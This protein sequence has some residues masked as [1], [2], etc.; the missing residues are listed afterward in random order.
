MTA[1]NDITGDSIQ[2]KIATENFVNNYDSVFNREYTVRYTEA[3]DDPEVASVFSITVV[4]SSI[5]DARR[6]ANAALRDNLSAQIIDVY[7]TE[8]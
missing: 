3:T 8:S 6:K 5:P 4:G 2:T 1:K 7:P